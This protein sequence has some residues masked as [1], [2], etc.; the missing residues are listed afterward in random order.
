MVANGWWDREQK[1]MVTCT[2]DA[3]VKN[4]AY[5]GANVSGG[6]SALKMEVPSFAEELKFQSGG[7][8]RVITFSLKA[9]AAI[10]MAGHKDVT[11]TW[12]DGRT[13]AWETSS[14]YQMQPFIEEFAKS[15]PVKSDYGKTWALSLPQKSYF[16]DAKATGAV[17]PA[18]WDLSFPHALRGAGAAEPDETFYEQWSSSPFADTYLTKLAEAAVDSLGLGSSDGTDY[19]GVSYSSVDYVGHAFG[20]RSWEIQDVLVR[21]DQNL[22]DLLKHLDAKVGRGN[23][24]LALTADHGVVPVPEDMLKTG[25]DAGLL[26]LPELQAR[27]EKALEAFHFVKPIAAIAGSE[28]YFTAGVYDKLKSDGPA[29]S[30]ALDAMLAQPGVLGVYRAEGLQTRLSGNNTLHDA[31]ADGYFPGR[32]GDLLIAPK[33]YWL[34]DSTPSGKTRTT[35]TGHGTPWNYDQHVPVFFFGYGIRAGEY[36]GAASPVDIAPTLASLCGITLAPR[37][38]RVLAEALQVKVGRVVAAAR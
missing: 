29:M 27:V 16:Y 23:Y 26:R 20:P 11:A 1:K 6:D 21:L 31:F 32:S 3:G 2:A 34:M 37:D 17:A 18:G 19:L 5:G 9:R 4:V 36:F 30:A 14:A 25:A 8:T 12:F 33:P 10:T 7:N 38:G 24:V 28:V 15:H 22:G 35:G 13:G